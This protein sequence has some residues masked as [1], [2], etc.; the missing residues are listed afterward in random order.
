MSDEPIIQDSAY[1]ASILLSHD[2]LAECR[3]ALDGFIDLHLHL[4]PDVVKRANND[5][6]FM[7]AARRIG[8]RAIMLKD[9]FTS[10]TGRAFLLRHL[11]ES[12]V[13]FGGLVLSA[14]MGGLNADAVE[15]ALKQGA[16]EIWLPTLYAHNHIKHFGG[17][18][19]PDFLPVH[20]VRRP[21]KESQG[22]LI[23]DEDNQLKSEV[24]EI[25][26]M[27]ADSDTV[28][29]TGHISREEICALLEAAG[30]VGVRKV[31]VAHPEFVA[32]NW[33]T[34]DQLKFAEMGAVLEHCASG[35]HET[36]LIATNIKKV[37][38]NRCV[39]SSDAGQVRRGHPSLV[40]KDFIGDLEDQGLTESEIWT[41]TRDNPAK[42]LNLT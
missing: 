35:H 11:Y 19:L 1:Y 16:R 13:V 26:A 12:P 27:I 8:Y 20:P 2:E 10:T 34:E 24:Q 42:L 32:T 40:M 18:T 21:A 4:A 38:A 29:S 30:K 25:L 14:P 15:V 37:G 22:L 39:L 36:K 41:M 7:E 33:S 6:Q 5:I 31:L 28:L 23:V 3:K 9:H 17:P